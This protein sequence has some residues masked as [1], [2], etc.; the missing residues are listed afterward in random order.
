M[1]LVRRRNFFSFC[2]F[3]FVF[4]L[5]DPPGVTCAYRIIT[6][7]RLHARSGAPD[8]AD[9]S[10]HCFDLGLP[11]YSSLSFMMPAG[12]LAGEA[13]KNLR[14]TERHLALNLLA[15]FFFDLEWKPQIAN[16][17]LRAT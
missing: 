10:I 4:S 2:A 7:A 17:K 6:L 1:T 8:P 15:N 3:F 16:L 5:W 9:H 11:C 12:I 14:P 13:E